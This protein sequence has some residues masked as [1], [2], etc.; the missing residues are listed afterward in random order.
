MDRSRL[1]MLTAGYVEL[2]RGTPL[3]LQ[4]YVLFYVLP[5]IGLILDPR[6]AGIAGIG[7]QLFSV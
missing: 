6:V 3:M 7:D 4:L 2:I 1:Q 5:K